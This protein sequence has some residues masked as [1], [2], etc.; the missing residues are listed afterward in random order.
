[1]QALLRRSPRASG[2]EPPR[3]GIAVTRAIF[4]VAALV[5]PARACAVEPLP[6]VMGLP[7]YRYLEIH[8]RAHAGHTQAQFELGYLYL[9]RQ[10]PG[11][12]ANA[13]VPWFQRAAVEGHHEAMNNLGVAYELGRGLAQNIPEAISWYELATRA[14]NPEAPHN[15]AL[16]FDEGKLHPRRPAQAERLYRIAA[17]RGIGPAAKRLA[18][19]Y[20]HEAEEEDFLVHA[21]RKEAARYAV[22]AAE[23]GEVWPADHPLQ[24]LV[25]QLT[26]PSVVLPQEPPAPL[27]AEPESEPEASEPVLAQAEI[28]PLD[29]ADPDDTFDPQVVELPAA[30]ALALEPEAQ[31]VEI[32]AD[33]L[34]DAIE[35]PQLVELT[36]PVQ[37]DPSYLA[38]IQ[39][40]LEPEPAPEPAASKN[41]MAV[42]AGEPI[43]APL[44]PNIPAAESPAWWQGMWTATSNFVGRGRQR[45]ANWSR[46]DYIL[47]GGIAALVAFGIALVLIA[48]EGDFVAKAAAE[49]KREKQRKLARRPH[50]KLPPMAKHNY[51][52]PFAGI[53]LVWVSPGTYLMGSAE[54]EG[55]RG[56]DEGPRTQVTLS[57]GFWLGKYP[58]TVAQYR[59]LTGRSPSPFAPAGPHAPVVNVSWH[60]AMGFCTELT[61]RERSSGRLPQGYAFTLPTEAQWEFACRAG[62][63]ARFSFG[64][65]DARLV[66]YGWFSENSEGSPQPVGRQLPNGYGLFDMHG[67][68]GEWCRDWYAPRL[69]GG[70]RDDPLGP[71]PGGERV[72]RGGSFGVPARY[73]RSASRHGYD[74]QRGFA[75]LGFRLCLE[76]PPGAILSPARTP[77]V[78]AR[79]TAPEPAR[80]V[81]LERARATV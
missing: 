20:F 70:R 51:E 12:P 49:E 45:L 21:D 26:S 59:L 10:V 18:E 73:C 58:V 2:F 42:A 9:T 74:P 71:A 41:A 64:E 29:G 35:A 13:A 33:P 47:A 67:N 63:G 28:E 17:E 43:A 46:E 38:T 23:L 48:R 4:A 39:T 40:A 54:E 22:L 50:L 27:S 72:Y 56:D 25:S 44:P 79:E 14:G 11:I 7:E 69:P 80:T 60:E 37:L 57:Q 76:A 75:Q 61:R 30:P 31:L 77:Q 3:A 52:I 6:Q 62:S 16:L 24:I 66:D 32:T 81:A 53:D 78:N 34:P 19:A 68:V 55:G 36:A 5:L 8:A 15:L 1:M 65:I